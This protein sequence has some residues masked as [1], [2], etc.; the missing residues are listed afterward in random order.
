MSFEVFMQV[1]C[2][3]KS[4]LWWK[5]G[6]TGEKSQAP[7]HF[8]NCWAHFDYFLKSIFYILYTVSKIGKSGVQRFKRCPNRSWNEKV[9]VIARKLD[10]AE[11]EFRTPQSKVRK[12][13]HRAKQGAK[14][15]HTTIQ[16]AKFIPRCENLSSRCI[17]FAHHNSRCEIHSNVRIRVRKFRYCWTQFWRTFWSSNY[18]YDMSF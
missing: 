16:G 6:K 18:A 17:N 8:V 4:K 2:L 7:P 3:Q 1:W 10:R 11:R 13:S 15:S 12:I 9:I 5:Q 14:I